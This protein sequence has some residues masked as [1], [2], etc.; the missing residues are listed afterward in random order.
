GSA[1]TDAN[2]ETTELPVITGNYA[3]D[4][5]EHQHIR[6][7]GA[8]GFGE[9]HPVLADLTP[10]TTVTFRAG[11]PVSPPEDF[12]TFTIGDSVD[13]R[14]TPPPVTLDYANMN[15]AFMSTT[16]PNDPNY[17]DSE[18][19]RNAYDPIRDAFVFKGFDLGL[20]A[21][22]AI[23]GCTVILEGSKLVF[24]P[25]NTPSLTISNG[26]SLIMDVDTDTNDLPKIMGQGGTND[27]VDVTIASGGLLDVNAGSISNLAPTNTK[28]GLLVV[29]FGGVLDMSG[30]TSISAPDITGLGSNFPIVHL[31]GGIFNADTVSIVAKGSSGTGV[32][33][34]SGVLN[35]VKLTVSGAE[36]GVISDYATVILDEYTSTDNTVG[37]YSVGSMSLPKYY[38][39]LQIE[40]ARRGLSLFGDWDYIWG[41]SY[42]YYFSVYN[43]HTKTIDLSAYIGE[44]DFLQPQLRMT[45]NGMWNNP[46]IG[47][48]FESFV[49]LDNL[50]VVME[51]TSGNQWIV[52][53]SSDV[54]YYPYSAN[55][56]ASGTS[57]A[58]YAGG[59][60]GVPNWD[61]SYSGISSSPYNSFGS[62]GPDTTVF[63][64]GAGDSMGELY[65]VTG[66]GY[67]EEFGFRYTQATSGSYPSDQTPFLY[68][69]DD[70]VTDWLLSPA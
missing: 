67:P 4:K 61:C 21:D 37:V 29:G 25:T 24:L 28:T 8:A 35:S 23:D 47:G 55:D 31:D 50:Q 51:D 39:S 20:D 14:L 62:A 27:V 22:M 52:D 12:D 64:T 65:G 13:I 2:G 9:A 5:F 53:D 1:T 16:D 10:A 3:G 26:G 43:W 48:G 33:S 17:D 60:G 6:A 38:S 70:H 11:Q 42:G 58:T 45:Y 44:T 56:P 69:G 32:Y 57:A 34:D 36:T 49:E 18:V 54:G 68:W 19:F 59:V 46:L 15:C 30:G 63:S 41:F 66:Y 40:N 7:S